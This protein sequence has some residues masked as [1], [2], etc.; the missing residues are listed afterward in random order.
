MILTDLKFFSETIGMR[1]T[2][3]VILPQWMLAE[4]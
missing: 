4:A 1:A 3:S 2:M